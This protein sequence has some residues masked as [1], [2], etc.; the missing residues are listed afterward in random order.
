M[1]SSQ[2][3]NTEKKAKSRKYN[4]VNRAAKSERTEKTIIEALVT[5]LVKRKGGD[6]SMEELA[7]ET[8]ISQRTV[9][10]F[11]KDKKTLHQAMD[12]YL[13]SYLQ[14][15]AEQ[16]QA[17][18]FIGFAKNAYVLFDRHEDLTLAYLLSPFGKEA[19]MVFRK[20]LNQAM[21]AKIVREK[22]LKLDSEKLRKLAIVTSLVNA[23]IW[24]DIKNDY[25]YSGTEMTAAVEWALSTLLEKL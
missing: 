6:V 2:N 13:F 1:K 25:G 14:T 15:S 23:K 16:M 12:E 19:R 21:V 8:G 7:V 9:F 11:F 18:D 24:Y 17:L 3:K 20:K 10:R 5:L 22:Q 4:N